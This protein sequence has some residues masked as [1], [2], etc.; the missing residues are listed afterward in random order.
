MLDKTSGVYYHV[1]RVK[2]QEDCLIWQIT[3]Q[4]H[5][6]TPAIIIAGLIVFAAICHD[7]GIV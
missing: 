2:A 5:I 1:K 7:T 3:V 4:T 6:I